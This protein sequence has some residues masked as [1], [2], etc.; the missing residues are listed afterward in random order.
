LESITY[1]TKATIR[2]TVQQ[3]I[4][5]RRYLKNVTP[6]TII[7]YEQA[8]KSF[9]GAIDSREAIVQRIAEL[10]ERGVQAV[11]VNSW[12]RVINAYWKWNGQ[13]I[14]IPRLKEEQKILA[15]FSTE[16]VK[17]LLTF[18]PKGTNATRVHTLACFLLDTGLRIDEGRT[19]QPADVDFNN[20]L[21]TVMGKGKKQRRV[22]ISFEGRKILFRY[23]QQNPRRYIFGTRNQ[24]ACTIRNLQRDFAQLCRK[25]GIAGVRCSFHTLRHTFSVFYLRKGGNLFYLS[26]I[27]GHTSVKTTE[28]YLQTLGIEDLQ[29]VHDGLS[30]LSA[31]R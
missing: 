25:I 1:E 21:V 19:I 27:L 3:F 15:T 30:L 16:Q 17:S 9:A 26:K 23:V 14:K 13:D 6:K 10:R 28:R 8:F 29:K 11:S 4:T 20:L 2:A 31:K 7:W 24:T 18:R 12:L 22:P 5:E